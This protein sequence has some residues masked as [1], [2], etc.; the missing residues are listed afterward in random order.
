MFLLQR[1]P[2]F[3]ARPRKTRVRVYTVHVDPTSPADD[4]GAELLR[5]GF[6]W[7]AALLTILW[8]LYHRLWGMTIVL[9]AV[10]AALGAAVAVLGLDPLSQ[11][12][13]EL[14]YL[15]LIG[16]HANDW[17]RRRL[18]RRGYIELGVATGRN[19]VAAE[20]RLFDRG[21]YAAS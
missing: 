7:P 20:Q 12:A 19:L 15:T 1:A 13:V 6:C 11:I 8:T 14:G 18:A 10:A 17:R 5:E 4:R 21:I 16:S 3:P 9:L 2:F